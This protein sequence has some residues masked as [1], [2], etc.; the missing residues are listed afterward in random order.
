MWL[1]VVYYFIYNIEGKI[2]FQ[3]WLITTFHKSHGQEAR[4][5]F[6]RN[7]FRTMNLPLFFCICLVNL[8][9]P[10][11]VHFDPKLCLLHWC[12]V[13]L[14]CKDIKILHTSKY[15]GEWINKAWSNRGL[16]KTKKFIRQLQERYYNNNVY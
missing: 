6:E 8:R 1:Y 3:I 11:S 16:Y 13:L 4:S 14:Y 10:W 12:A 7:Y 15:L 2:V 5:I 9:M